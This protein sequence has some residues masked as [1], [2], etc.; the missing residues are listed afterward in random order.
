[1]PSKAAQAAARLSEYSGSQAVVLNT[2]SDFFAVS[3]YSPEYI[4]Y[5]EIFVC[6]TNGVSSLEHINID[7][8]DYRFLL[9]AYKFGGADS[10]SDMFEKVQTYLPVKSFDKL[11]DVSCPVYLCTLEN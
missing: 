2:N 11:T 3:N 4:N 1:M 9:Y 7:D 10:E 6:N 5:R 8:L